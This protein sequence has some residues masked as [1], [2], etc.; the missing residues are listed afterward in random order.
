MSI[1]EELAAELRQ[2]MK[3]GDAGRRDAIRQVETEVARAKSEPG[4]T[5]GVDDALYL[6]VI[7]SYVRKMTKVRDEYESF[8]ERGE[9]QAKKL[10]FEVEYLGR[11]LPKAL[12]DEE[13]AVIVGDAIAEL[14]VAGDPKQS[15]R[16]IGH[17]MK[18]G[19]AG[20][21]GGLVS[22]LVRERLGAG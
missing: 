13:T 22:R 1:K 15:G 8:G 14:G 20:L 16:V 3:A 4:F 5:G 11:W 21:D 2:A 6:K 18:A 10:G 7:G 9:S 12:G 19:R 17:I